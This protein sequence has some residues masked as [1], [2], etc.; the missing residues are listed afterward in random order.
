MAPA[1]AH[2]DPSSLYETLTSHTLGQEQRALLDLIDDLRSSSLSS[3]IQLPQIVVV[4]DQSAGK[5]SVLTAI[6]GVHFPRDANACTRFPTEVRLRTEFLTSVTSSGVVDLVRG[7]IWFH[8]SRTW[9]E[10]GFSLVFLV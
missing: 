9:L 3:N 6:T 7:W 2:S 1:A 8:L 4:G 10:V 5:S